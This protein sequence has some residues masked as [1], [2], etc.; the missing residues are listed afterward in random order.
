QASDCAP[1]A[2][3][4]SKSAALKAEGARR[5]QPAPFSGATRVRVCSANSVMPTPATTTATSGAGGLAAAGAASRAAASAQAGRCTGRSPQRG[6][7]LT[8]GAAA[9]TPSGPDGA[10]PPG[11]RRC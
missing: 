2:L 7:I 11:G 10:L 3:Q 6:D 9:P 8:A 1:G 4:A 5:N